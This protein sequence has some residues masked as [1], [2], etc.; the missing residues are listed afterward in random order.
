MT[1][2]ALVGGA[3]ILHDV[4][5]LGAGSG[6]RLG[7]PLTGL[8]TPTLHGLWQSAP[9]LHDGS[10]PALRDV[11]VTRNSSDQHGA[12]SALAANEIDDLVAYLLSLD[13][14]D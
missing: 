1:D 4:G 13:G 2:S 7:V 6:S 14:S 12:T 8:D 11:L 10:A 9:Y 3:P 5:T